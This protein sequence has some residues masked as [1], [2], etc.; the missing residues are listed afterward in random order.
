[1]SSRNMYLY[2]FYTD[3]RIFYASFMYFNMDSASEQ[4]NRNTKHILNFDRVTLDS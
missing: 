2:I 3:I 1:M 4:N